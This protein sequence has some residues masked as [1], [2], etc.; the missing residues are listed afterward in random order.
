[1]RRAAPMRCARLT[2]S[3]PSNEKAAVGAM[4][5]RTTT[6]TVTFMRPFRL[7]GVDRTLPPAD[8]RVVTDEEPI[9]GLS[10]PAYRR[11]STVIFVPAPSGSAVEMV[12]VDPLDLEAA[13]E[14]DATAH[15]A[16]PVD[17]VIPD[18]AIVTVV[19]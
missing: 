7:T 8:Y 19:P 14:Q 9:E 16:Q 4:S 10:F 1:M 11:I 3:G 13:L 17:G 12:T 15:D 18:A 2:E 6:K 5:I